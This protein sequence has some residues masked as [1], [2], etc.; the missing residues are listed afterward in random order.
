MQSVHTASF[1][2]TAVHAKLKV[3]QQ[4]MITA[5]SR[6]NSHVKCEGQE[7]AKIETRTQKSTLL[8]GMSKVC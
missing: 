5:A 3:P 1:L 7:A 2:H 6:L 4:L 8:M